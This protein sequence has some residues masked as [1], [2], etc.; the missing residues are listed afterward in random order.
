MV[1]LGDVV[2]SIV[3]TSDRSGGLLQARATEAWSEVVGPQIESHTLGMKMRGRELEVH[4]D[5]HAWAAQLSLLAEDLRER[6]NSAIGEES[7]G[8]IRFTVS[9]AVGDERAARKAEARSQRRYG[10]ERIDPVPLTEQELR[11]IEEA[12]ASIDNDELRAAAIRA[13][14]RDIEVKKGRAARKTPQGSAEGS[15]GRKKPFLP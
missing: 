1:R 14:I 12:A 4:V 6:V 3:R 2:R 8:S 5:S 15:T 10:G 7:V 9:R 11:E 13:Q